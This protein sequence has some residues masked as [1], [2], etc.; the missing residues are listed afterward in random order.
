M[1]GWVLLAVAGGVGSAA[2]FGVGEACRQ[3]LPNVPV[4][5]L[6]VNATGA[7]ALGFLAGSGAGEATARVVGTGFLGGYTTFSTWIVESAELER[8]RAAVNLVVS[9]A[10]GLVGVA[11]G[12]AIARG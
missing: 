6:V 1:T 10:L 11:A 9:L 3:R 5:T 4:G 12:R 8:R 2:R 7:F